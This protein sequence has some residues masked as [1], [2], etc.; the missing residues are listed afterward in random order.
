MSRVI[1]FTALV[2]AM[3]AAACEQD[4][5]TA[6]DADERAGR[7]AAEGAAV[8]GAGSTD[9][10]IVMLDNCSTT[11]ADYDA[12]GGC[13]ESAHPS[14]RAFRGD[15]PLDELFELLGSPLAPDDQLIGHPSWRNEPS[16]L[17]MS[18]GR[19]LRVTNR[20]GRVHTF[21]EV[22]DFGG[23][24]LPL[25]N[26]ALLPAPECG[27]DFV[28]NADVEFVAP[29]ETRRLT[30]TTSGLHKFQC[31]IHPWMRAAVRAD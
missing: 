25:L 13:P 9:P 10:N 1:G 31:C 27:A 16:Y 23:G 19:T 14:T 20:G 22:A 11:D 4:A 5:A 2:L 17:T 21:T 26:G 18:A 12:L 28:P 8:P 29:G 30:V 15:V 3:S 24:F 7:S 6:P